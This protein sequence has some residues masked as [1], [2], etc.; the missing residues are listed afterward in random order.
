M[1]MVNQW[2]E[3]NALFQG[4][5]HQF[6]DCSSPT[7]RALRPQFGILLRETLA[8]CGI[9]GMREAVVVLNFVE[10][11]SFSASHTIHEAK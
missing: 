11:F 4:Q 7:R 10:L 6:L 2:V 8:V 1:D 3:R 9:R 5:C